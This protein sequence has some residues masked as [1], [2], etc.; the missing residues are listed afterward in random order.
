MQKVR[1]ALR[2]AVQQAVD[3][4][5]LARNVVAAAR[6][7]R[8]PQRTVRRVLPPAHVV[9]FWEAARGHP[10]EALWRLAS[11]VPSRS[12]ELRALEWDDLTERADGTARLA[13]RRSKTAPGV[14]AVELDAGLVALLRDHR[15]RQREHQL[16]AGRALGGAWA[17]VFCTATGVLWPVAASCGRSDGSWRGRG[18]PDKAQAP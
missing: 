9:R 15:R 16:A 12:G 13:I 10:L 17:L 14:R 18:L 11:L 8:V 5:L 3:D 2:Q 6:P 4:G 7:P 1:A